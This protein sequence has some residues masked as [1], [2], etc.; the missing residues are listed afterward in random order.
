[1]KYWLIALFALMLAGGNA[2]AEQVGTAVIDGRVVILDSNGTWRYRDQQPTG[3]AEDCDSVTGLLI[4]PDKKLWIKEPKQ[5][6]YSALYSRGSQ[7]YFGVISEPFGIDKGVKYEFLEKVI[8]ENAASAS[9][10]SAKDVAVFEMNSD[11]G[12]EPGLRSMIYATEIDGTPFVYYN[13]Y[14]IYRQKTIQLVFW[15]IGREP[16]PD[17]KAAVKDM[18]GKIDF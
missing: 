6:D 1:M 17:F 5:D 13:A 10:K 3:G 14:K 2:R 11:T 8:I 7:Y 9:G 12:F 16:T 4:C 15:T 18:L